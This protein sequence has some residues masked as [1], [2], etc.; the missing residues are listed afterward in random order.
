V[1]IEQTTAYGKP[2]IAANIY[3]AP[4]DPARPVDEDIP[5]GQGELVVALPALT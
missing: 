5:D 1:V 2:K 3:R 4:L